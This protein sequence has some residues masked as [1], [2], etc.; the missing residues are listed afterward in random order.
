MKQFLVGLASLVLITALVISYFLFLDPARA[1]NRSMFVVQFIQNPQTHQDWVTPAL[2]QCAGA[3]FLFPTT[4]LIGYLWDDSFKAGHRH[5]GIDIFGGTAPGQTAVYAAYDGYLSRPSDWKSTI[6]IRIAS[7]PLHPS[8]QVWTYYT[9]MADLNG[10]SFVSPQFQAGTSEEFVKAGTFLGFQ[11]DYS[12]DP[13]NPVGVHLHF[14][15]VRDDGS[16]HYT[17]E[18]EIKNTLDPSL[19]LGYPLNAASNPDLP[20]T[21][22]PVNNS[23]SQ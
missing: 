21:C 13:N 16:G 9:H 11:G 14:S 10:N 23:N 6:I 8:T 4:G 20:L 3:P 15:I 7:D 12:G 1:R 5:Q 19:Y 22:T 2:S 17:N 18:L